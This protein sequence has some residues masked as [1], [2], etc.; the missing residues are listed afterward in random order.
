[1]VTVR[2]D[3][4]INLQAVHECAIALAADGITSYT[5]TEGMPGPAYV[6]PIPVLRE[7]NAWRRTA[8]RDGALQAITEDTLIACFALATGRR[9]WSPIPTIVD[10]P[11]V[12]KSTYGNDAALRQR[13][14]VRWDTPDLLPGWRDE[15]VYGRL[16]HLDYWDQEPSHLGRFYPMSIPMLTRRFVKGYSTDHQARDEADRGSWEKQRLG[17]MMLGKRTTPPARLYVCT[18]V[19]GGLSREYVQSIFHLFGALV[20]VSIDQELTAVMDDPAFMEPDA[21]DLVRT[22][23]AHIRKALAS[24]CTHALLADADIRFTPETIVGMFRTGYDFVQCPYPRRDGRG[25]SI[26]HLPTTIAKGGFRPEDVERDTLPIMGTG[27]GCTLLTRAG[28]QKMWDHY[29]DEPDP[30]ELEDLVGA[31]HQSRREIVK[32]AYEL[33]RR[34]GPRLAYYDFPRFDQHPVPYETVALFQL[35]LGVDDE[36]RLPILYGEDISFCRR[37]LALGEEVRMYIGDGSPVQHMGEHLYGGTITQFT[38][39]IREPDE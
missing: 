26:R 20:D 21:M 16:T 35:E 5:T 30:P 17:H 28:M 24:G 18:P 34:K 39:F 6:L 11:S 37:W 14:L 13:P 12:V 2:P 19:R 25:Y 22:R 38:G 33:G 4:I 29:R 1:M 31:H 7:F 15:T 23:S 32:A 27:L 3:Q 9:I 8:L 10:H 36:V